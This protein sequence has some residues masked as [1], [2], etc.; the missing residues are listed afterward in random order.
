MK[1]FNIP[2]NP[3]TVGIGAALVVVV[4]LYAMFADF[5]GEAPGDSDDNR[6]GGEDL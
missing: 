5:K 1:V 4:V 3:R 6:C 2:L